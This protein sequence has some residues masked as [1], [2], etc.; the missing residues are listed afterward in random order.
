[1]TGPLTL[2][3]GTAADLPEVMATM[4]ASFDRRF[5]EAWTERQ[6]AGILLLSGVWLTLARVGGRPAG[7]ALNRVVVDEA[8]LLLLGVRPSY[9][10][11]GVGRALLMASVTASEG[12]G[13]VR[14]HLEVR[15]GNPAMLVY[16]RA[17]FR[18]SGRRKQY[19]FGSAGRSFD[20]LTLSRDLPRL[21]PE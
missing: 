1:M 6:C 7:F 19:Y 14:M 16:S 13:A 11:A 20:A 5:G 4:D 15:D 9:R 21:K 8:E 12:R 3:P 17:G 18:Q 2:H 10:R